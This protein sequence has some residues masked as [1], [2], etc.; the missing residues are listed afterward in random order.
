[1]LGLRCRSLHCLIL[2]HAA[3]GEWTDRI[4]KTRQATHVCSISKQ[5]LCIVLLSAHN[6]RTKTNLYD[7]FL[8]IKS[9]KLNLNFRH[10]PPPHLRLSN[11]LPLAIRPPNHP[12]HRLP[13]A[14]IIDAD[15]L[16]RAAKVLSCR[17]IMELKPRG[18]HVV[19]DDVRSL[20]VEIEARV[21]FGA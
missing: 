8:V 5:S 21:P 3:R 19:V 10:L 7:R 14:S 12:I 20:R 6:P 13:R 16:D 4:I 18:C 17:K 1:M 9:V 15:F 11:H 2:S